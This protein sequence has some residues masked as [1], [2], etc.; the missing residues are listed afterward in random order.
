MLAIDGLKSLSMIL[1]AVLNNVIVTL[2]VVVAFANFDVR[3]GQILEI[4]LKS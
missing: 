4:P 2:V 3:Y 1:I